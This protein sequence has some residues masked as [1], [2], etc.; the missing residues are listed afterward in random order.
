MHHRLGLTSRSG[1]KRRVRSTAKHDGVSCRQVG[2]GC[3][4]LVW[5]SE[6][7]DLARGRAGGRGRPTGRRKRERRKREGARARGVGSA[8]RSLRGARSRSASRAP[9]HL[10]QGAAPS[11]SPASSARLIAIRSA[12]PLV[13]GAALLT[14]GGAAGSAA[15]AHCV[16]STRISVTLRDDSSRRTTKHG[17]SRGAP[18]LLSPDAD[19]AGA[20]GSCAK[21]VRVRELPLARQRLRAHGALAEALGS[22]VSRA[23][24]R[25]IKLSEA[26][27]EEALTEAE[28]LVRASQA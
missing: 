15:C 1:A 4:G 17:E 24:N 8:A 26:E 19:G 25:A 9:Q 6:P 11:Y 5:C 27:Q 2:L 18:P 14:S 7:Q 20:C 16:H 3:V 22:L 21:S 10:E 23:G 28:E 12:S 13:V